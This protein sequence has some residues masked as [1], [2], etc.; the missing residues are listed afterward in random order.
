[1]GCAF[2]ETGVGGIGFLEPRQLQ[3]QPLVSYHRHWVPPTVRHKAIMKDVKAT[4]VLDAK[5]RAE[6]IVQF[7]GVKEVK[8]HRNA[9]SVEELDLAPVQ[10][11]V[12]FEMPGAFN[13][14]DEDSWRATD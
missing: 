10:A 9:A 1:V 3:H 8:A 7:V 12:E 6:Q 11:M 2:H 13:R 14:I 5:M 4:Q